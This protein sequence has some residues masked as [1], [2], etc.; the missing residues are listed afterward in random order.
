M[1]LLLL[2]L[3]LIALFAL[4]ALTL[5]L[6]I[7]G[8]YRAGTARRRARRWLALTN[9][10]TIGISA[11]L[12]LATA[13]VSSIWIP[14]AF[15][16]S[17]GG[18]GGGLVLGIIGLRLTRWEATSQSLHYTPNPWL[19]LA[20]TAGVTLRLAFG[21]WRA[22]HAWHAAPAGHSWLA[23]SGLAGSM[24]TGAVV[25]GHYLAFWLGVW[26]RA[27]KVVVPSK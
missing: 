26:A 18:F 10:L 25:L 20:I 21:L 24:A 9:A 1:P 27:R 4:F 12:F 15:S 8:R 17:A 14:G 23:E 16:F 11:G 2:A 19:V 22:W 7:I 5:P 6:S 13:A 3:A